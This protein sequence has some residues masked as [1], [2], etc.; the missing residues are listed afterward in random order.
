MVGLRFNSMNNSMFSLKKHDYQSNRSSKLSELLER[1][2]SNYSTLGKDF[3]ATLK[4]QETLRNPFEY[5][6]E[7]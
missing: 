6:K 1:F 7:R 3:G 4:K 5:I 2:S